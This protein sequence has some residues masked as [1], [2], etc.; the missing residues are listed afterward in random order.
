MELLKQ[1]KASREEMEGATQE[2]VFESDTLVDT[3]ESLKSHHL[4][5][6]ANRLGLPTPRFSADESNENETW[7]RAYTGGYYLSRAAQSDLRSR[8]RLEEK[9]RRETTAFWV[10]DILVPALSVLLGIIGATTGLV[11][12]FH[13]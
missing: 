11:A 1:R 13:K 12:V 10:K 7:A 6:R 9:E 3:I 2:T 4:L 8:I 5:G